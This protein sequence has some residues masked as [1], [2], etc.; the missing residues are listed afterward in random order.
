MVVLFDGV[1]NL[2]NA[3][4][5]FVIDHDRF[6]V[7]VFGAQQSARG[8]AILEEL[9]LPAPVLAGIVVV[10]GR[11]VYTDSAAILEVCAR[12]PPP[13]RL[14]GFLRIIPRPIRDAVYRWV[15]RHRYAWFG[16]SATCRV[17][18]P[19]LEHRFLT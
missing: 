2:C 4:V 11:R 18:A 13:W 3:W 16:K 15:A 7:F 12:L 6:G 1:C 9:H 10:A 19:E 17:P 14:I 5:N 8:R